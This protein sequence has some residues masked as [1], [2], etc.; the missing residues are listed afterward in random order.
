MPEHSAYP[1][2]ST[3]RYSELVLGVLRDA[4]E[5]VGGEV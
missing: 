2:F 3:Y 4:R 1:I 5:G